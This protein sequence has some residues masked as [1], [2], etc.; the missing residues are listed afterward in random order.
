M[1]QAAAS[2]WARAGAFG[3]VLTGRKAIELAKIEK[4]IKVEATEPTAQVLSVIVDVKKEL[5][6]RNLYDQIAKKF[7]RTADVL[8]NNAGSAGAAFPIGQLPYDDFENVFASHFLGSTLMSKYFISSQAKPEDPV[9]TIV[10]IT[11][12]IAAM[13]LPGLAAYSIAKLAGQRMMEYLD[14]E[15]S[16]LRTFTLSP[17]IIMTQMTDDSFKPFA[18]D[19]VELPGLFSV[20]LSQPRA[21]FLRGGLVGINWDIEELEAHQEEI[22]EKRLLKLQ[23]VP[24]QFGVDGQPWTG[25]K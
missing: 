4:K 1:Y 22:K 21:E 5:D 18:K 6:V 10:Y 7:G 23:Y 13:I 3:I 15:Y 20:Y 8:L 17:G 12:G 11:S 19:H 25:T 9:G 16:N 2:V 24:A 14:A